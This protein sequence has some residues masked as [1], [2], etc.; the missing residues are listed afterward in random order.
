MRSANG[1]WNLEISEKTITWAAGLLSLGR[2]FGPDV[3]YHP[4]TPA[5]NLTIGM[6]QWEQELQQA[7]P[8]KSEEEMLTKCHNGIWTLAIGKV[9]RSPKDWRTEAEEAGRTQ[10]HVLR[11]ESACLANT[12]PTKVLGWTEE[13]LTLSNLGAYWVAI[14]NTWGSRWIKELP[15]GKK[16]DTS[17][18][19][20][21]MKEDKFFQTTPKDKSKS[22][23]NKNNTKPTSHETAPP[24]PTTKKTS[25][26]KQVDQ[27]FPFLNR[28][29]AP[30]EQRRTKKASYNYKTYLQM[31]IPIVV[32]N[33]EE[34]GKTLANLFKICLS[35]YYPLSILCVK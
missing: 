20:P 23:P 16:L 28:P 3:I 32:E 14:N 26:A 21:G 31:S 24:D 29:S 17:S 22:T 35:I 11:K 19:P 25:F 15:P 9:T 34:Y 33:K 30:L 10:G 12:P 13:G 6:A 7:L 8:Y 18:T 4:D 5:K 27:S 2:L 1:E